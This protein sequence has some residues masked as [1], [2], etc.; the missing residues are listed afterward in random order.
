[1]ALQRMGSIKRSIIA[2]TVELLTEKR[3]SFIAAELLMFCSPQ[4]GNGET[5]KSMALLENNGGKPVRK[6]CCAVN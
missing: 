3:F 1:M 5:V 2:S 6:Y 4:Q